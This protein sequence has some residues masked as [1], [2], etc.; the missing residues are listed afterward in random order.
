[1]KIDYKYI[2]HIGAEAYP[3]YKK[4]GLGDVLGS[5][6]AYLQKYT[7]V[8]NIVITPFYKNISHITNTVRE[9]VILFNGI[10][11]TY[12]VHE[13]FW[14]NVHYFFIEN[15]EVFSWDE[16][17]MDGSKPYQSSVGLQ[18]FIFAKTAVHFLEKENYNCYKIITHDWHVCG[19]YGYLRKEIDTLHIIH[20]YNHQGE[21]YY[22]IC[23]YID[24]E[25]SNK[26]YKQYEDTGYCNMN[27]FAIYY[28]NNILTV[29]PNYAN[30]LYSGK[31]PH[32]GLEC[33][34]L[35]K[36]K[37]TGI[38]NGI[39]DSVWNPESDNYISYNYDEQS[40]EFKILNKQD[41]L[42]EY[43]I[44][45]FKRP[46]VIYLS[47]LTA[48]KGI[49]LFV[50]IRNGK[51]FNPEDRMRDIINCG[52]NLIICGTPSGGVMGDI[53]C[54]LKNLEV[55]YKEHFKYINNYSEEIAHNLFAAADIFL[56]PSRY[57]PCGLTQM[58]AM[59]YGTVPL[60]TQV[61]GLKDTIIDSFENINDGTGF[62]MKEYSYDNM[63]DSLKKIVKIYYYDK[64]SWNRIIKNGMK[65]NNSW[66]SRIPQYVKFLK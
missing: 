25:L 61:G 31:A 30:E 36:S 52:I 62:F 15:E 53:D 7:N 60:S 40:L 32:T 37:I 41:L 46:L 33:L 57:E 11:Y 54:Q 4:G 9:D 55:K 29:S 19:I 13:S 6:P 1:M 5:L 8:K 49:D 38:L 42:N 64:N 22:D 3:F 21:L 23:E 24:E 65:Q 27:L 51:Y 18:Y 16:I 2:I 63:L 45:D 47:R 58:Y 66:K 34:G 17:Y 10:E 50:N 20:N 39:D 26:I 48:Q 35:S 28:A 59:K 14:K 56:M 12:R 43:N 44:K